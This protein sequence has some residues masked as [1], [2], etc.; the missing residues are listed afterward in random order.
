LPYERESFNIFVLLFRNCF[1]EREGMIVLKREKRR[2]EM[3]RERKE[4]K[5]ERGERSKR[6]RKGKKKKEEGKKRKE[7]KTY[8]K[9]FIKI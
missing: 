4:T 7:V 8:F 1:E 5:R 3:F 9:L 6:R 2:E